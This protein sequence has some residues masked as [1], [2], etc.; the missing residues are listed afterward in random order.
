MLR[1]P[2]FEHIEVERMDE[3]I[4]TLDE[5]RT[6][7]KLIA[8]GTDLLPRIQH[9]LVH[10]IRKVFARPESPGRAFHEHRCYQSLVHNKF[11]G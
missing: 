8:G 7:A 6:E 9:R 10:P 2:K 5:F 4:S 3:L 1:L 11:G